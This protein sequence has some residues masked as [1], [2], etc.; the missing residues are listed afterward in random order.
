MRLCTQHKPEQGFF[1]AHPKQIVFAVPD[2]I[3]GS[4]SLFKASAQQGAAL[5]KRLARDN[6]PGIDLEALVT[7]FA[8][9][10]DASKSTVYVVKAKDAS[11]KEVY[12]AIAAA[13]SGVCN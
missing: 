13:T 11:T 8:S 9:L 10:L 5:F 2:S 3:S 6:I 4:G 12:Q 7:N 1:A